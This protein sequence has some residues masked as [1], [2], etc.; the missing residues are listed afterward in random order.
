MPKEIDLDDD[1][2]VGVDCVDDDDIASSSD[3]F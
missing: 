3:T 2:F 1:V